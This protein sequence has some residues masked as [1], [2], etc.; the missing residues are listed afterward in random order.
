MFHD[1]CP[2]DDDERNESIVTLVLSSLKTRSKGLIVDVCKTST[3]YGYTWCSEVCM[4][5]VRVRRSETCRTRKTGP[6]L[7]NEERE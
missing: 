4:R 7:R 3:Q 1:V 5:H 2:P 6:P